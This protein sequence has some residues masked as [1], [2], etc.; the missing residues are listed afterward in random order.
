MIQPLRVQLMGA[1]GTAT[2]NWLVVGAA[3]PAALPLLP[4]EVRLG[5]RTGPL[6]PSRLRNRDM[7]RVVLLLGGDTSRPVTIPLAS[8]SRLD[9][10]RAGSQARVAARDV[11]G[12]GT[13]G[14]R[15]RPLPGCCDPMVGGAHC[16]RGRDIRGGGG[17]AREP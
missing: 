7:A 9:E 5:R 3:V 8:L 16:R 13:A 6:G 10:G 11:G 1:F 14:A 2:F 15:G 4:Q 17:L 12:G